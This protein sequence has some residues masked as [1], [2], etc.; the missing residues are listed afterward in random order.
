MYE[1][2]QYWNQV[3]NKFKFDTLHTKK[4]NFFILPLVSPPEYGVFEDDPL[5]LFNK[6]GIRI[7]VNMRYI[8]QPWRMAK[9]M[10]THVLSANYGL[11]RSSLNVG[12]V[13]RFGH[14]V[15]PLD[16]VLKARYDARSIENY[17]GTGN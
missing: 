3:G 7:S 5:E 16:L 4:Y 12:Y 15:G 11:F 6:T 14:A 8:P 10:H 2:I 9:Y 17:F 1:W 13:G